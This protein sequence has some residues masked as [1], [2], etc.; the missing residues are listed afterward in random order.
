MK[1]KNSYSY[2]INR[3]QTSKS[4]RVENDRIKQKSFLFSSFP[5]TNIYGFQNGNIR[6]QLI[7]DFFSRYQRM[8]NF[9]VMYPVGYDSLGLKENN[10]ERIVFNEITKDV[11]LN[12]FNKARKIDDDLVN[13]FTEVFLGDTKPIIA[14]IPEFN[15]PN[16]MTYVSTFL[17]KMKELLYNSDTEDE[18]TE[19]IEDNNVSTQ[20][21]TDTK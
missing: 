8:D 6:P 11:I 5:K 16:I 20:K 7:G 9:N 4:F 1:L 19:E 10:Y 2:W 12:S 21:N 3:W 13:A 15:E 14:D 17:D 18:E